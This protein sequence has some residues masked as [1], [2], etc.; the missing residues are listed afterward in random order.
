MNVDTPAPVGLDVA[1]ADLVAAHGAFTANTAYSGHSITSRRH[2][3]CLSFLFCL[4]SIH[5][6]LPFG[7]EFY[8]FFVECLQDSPRENAK[9]QIRLQAAINKGNSFL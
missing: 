2:K 5:F 4:N 8:T 7:N 6:N 9:K 1:V 3:A